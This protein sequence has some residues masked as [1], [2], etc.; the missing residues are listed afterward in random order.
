MECTC[1]QC[2]WEG[3]SQLCNNGEFEPPTCYMCES[4]SLKYDD[5]DPEYIPY[6]S[7]NK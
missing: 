5:K 7:T 1:R 3:D 2:G 4:S 6:L